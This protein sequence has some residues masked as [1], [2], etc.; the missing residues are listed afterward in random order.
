MHIDFLLCNMLLWKIR[1]A[2]DV[3][4]AIGKQLD[5]IGRWVGVDRHFTGQTFTDLHFS[6]IDWNDV[7]Q[8]NSLQGGLQ[9]WNTSRA[10]DG[11]F[12]QFSDVKSVT[13]ALNDDDF[14]ILIKLKIIKNNT[15]MTCKNID[16]AIFNFFGTEIYTTWGVMTLT[17][18][19][20]TTSKS[21]IQLAKDK[22]C[23]P[24][25]TAVNIII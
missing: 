14:R 13:N 11:T 21:I 2:F 22:N 10:E 9:N 23:L 8:P 20:P 15:V 4:T 18:N 24:V 17:Y 3:D 16:N 25:P 7:S 6:L 12:L 1:D 19:Y 5:I